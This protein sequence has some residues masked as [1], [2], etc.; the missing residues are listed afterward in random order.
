M[1]PSAFFIARP[2]GTALLAIGLVIVG[3]AAYFSMPVA[4]LPSIEFPTI[5]V[6]A[7]RPGADPETM[8]ATVAA[9]IER[10]LGEIAGV[11]E[12]TSSS[13]FGSTGITVQFDLS[14][15]IDGAAR[16][17]QA[18]INAASTDLPSD[19]PSVP[20]FRKFNPSAA[21]IMI[22]ALTSDQLSASAIYDAADTVIAPRMSQV[23]GVADVSVSGADQPAI[24]I[25]L[26]P[27][28]LAAMGLSLAEVRTAVTNATAVTPLGAIDGTTRSY[29]LGMNDQ[30]RTAEEYGPIIVK[31]VGS[32]VVRLQDIATIEAGPRNTRSQATYNQKPAVLLIITKQPDANVLETVDAVKELIPELKRWVPAGLDISVLSDR[33]LTLRASVHDMLVTLGITIC[34]VMAVVFVFLRRGPPTLAAGITVPLSLAGTFALMWASGF[35]V[36]NI[37]LL[38]LVVAVG[39]VVDDAIVMI[40]NVYSRLEEGMTPMEASKLGAQEIGFTVISISVSLAAAFIPLL[41]QGGVV[42][43][44][45]QEFSWTLLYAIFVSTLVSLSVTPVICAYLI[46]ATPKTET[47]FD[48]VFERTMS[49]IISRYQGSLGFAIHR[50]WLMLLVLAACI[51]LTVKLFMDLPKGLFPQDDTGF[52]FG[53]TE[54]AAD[55][56][57]ES[58]V[59]LQQKA[60]ELVLADPAVEGVGSSL[61]AQGPM[62]GAGNTGRLFINLKPLAQRNRMSTDQVIAR[63]RPKLSKLNG[64]QVFLAGAR[65]VR[66]GGRQTKSEFQYTIWSQNL[67]DLNAAIARVTTALQALPQLADVSS[68]RNKGGLQANIIIDRMAAARLGVSIGAIDEA[69][70]SAF[71]QRQIATIYSTR[72]QYRVVLELEPRFQREV[73]D[74][75]R[76]YVP[77]TGGA[78]VP[79]ANLIR[80]ERGLS[81]LA[82]NHTGPF[83]SATISY[84]LATGATLDAASKA[85]AKAIAELRLPATVTAE[86][87]GDAKAFMSNA[88]MQP[89]LIVAALVSVYIVLGVLYESFVHPLTILSTLPSAGLGALLALSI[90]G[91]ELSVIA[92]IGIILLIGIVKKN[93]IMLVDFALHAERERGLTP[94]Q[95]IAEASVE[96]FRPILMTTLASLLGALPLALAEGPGSE[97]RRPLGVAIIGGLIVSQ[98][99]TLY[100][101]PAMYLLLDRLRRIGR[102]R[103]KAGPLAGQAAPAE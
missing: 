43:R 27:S 23:P 86:P 55:V 51:G 73:D 10:R 9:P 1:S 35:S 30:L 74:I 20:T 24:R 67:E 46:K 63:L 38:A 76:V 54:A 103:P 33:T 45:L 85:I 98:V 25:R 5:R 82:V 83:P 97:L 65:D 44:L 53:Q 3:I 96:R 21:P 36:N 62:A 19:M 28:R 39:F 92:M 87:S 100:T 8:A 70:N 31:V 72:N 89:L 61:G 94:E 13:N 59:K 6:Q 42:G 47:W 68:D 91:L 95:A 93:G 77:G 4:S 40:E 41:F 71:A 78:A 90:M 37:S 101:T 17:V 14:R 34:L 57:Y 22:L 102:S 81:P 84:G 16:D 80:I 2:V 88:A 18:A 52:I 99:L 29:T 49:A 26:D 48:R 12:L 75:L 15:R 69:L 7:S 50:K 56:S 64:I 11:S 60:A 58:M 32:T 79:L 66:V